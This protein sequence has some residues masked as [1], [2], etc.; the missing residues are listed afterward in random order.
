MVM[1]KTKTLSVSVRR[2]PAEIYEFILDP[3]NLPT[4]APAFS[5]S[6]IKSGD[7]WRVE[8]PDGLVTIRF[9]ERN[10][11]GV[12]DHWVTMPSGQEVLNPMRVIPNGDGSEVVFTIY[13]MP[14]MSDDKFEADAKMVE[15][16]LQTLKITLEG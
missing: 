13:Q 3:E 11:F 14:G 6:V 9:V 2:K 15:S 1:S 5:Q 7:E 8:S 4:W 10:E 12:L 16:D